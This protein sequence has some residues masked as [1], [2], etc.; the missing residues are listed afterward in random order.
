VSKK[1]FIALAE[2]MKEARPIMHEDTD[3]FRQWYND[4][5]ALAR[6]CQEQNP[7]FNRERWIGYI[8]GENGP[9]GGT[10]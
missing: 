9:N 5:L 10:R 6:F 3:K 8:K 2:C 7:R 1:H 4:V